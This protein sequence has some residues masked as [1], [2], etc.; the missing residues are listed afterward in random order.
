MV[1]VTNVTRDLI[2]VQNVTLHNAHH[3]RQ[4]YSTKMVHVGNANH[5]LETAQYVIKQYVPIVHQG[6]FCKTIHAQTVH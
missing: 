2:I 6:I 1:H 3:V 4:D 5:V